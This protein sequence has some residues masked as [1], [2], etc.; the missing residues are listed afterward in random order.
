MLIV[1]KFGGTSVSNSEC[2]FNVAK[3]IKETQ[4]KN[5]NI[6]V[7]VSAQGDTTDKFLEKV[8]E[9][10]QLASKREIDVL[11]SAGEQIS[12]ALLAMALEK[13][14][15]K[16]ISLTGWQAGFKTCKSYGN[17]RIEGIFP[18]RIQYELAQNKVVIVAGFQGINQNYDITTMGRGGSDTSA[19]ALA[20]AL[21]ADQCR[22]YTDVEGIYTANPRIVPH[23]KFLDV[24]PYEDVIQFA[25][26][27]AR[28]LNKRS[29]EIA[30]K[31]GIEISVLS[32]FKN[33][34]NSSHSKTLV[35]EIENNSSV[36]NIKG[37]ALDNNL[38]MIKIFN[39]NEINKLSNEFAK[40]KIRVINLCA[41]EKE[42]NLLINK[43]NLPETNLIFKKIIKNLNFKLEDNISK[44][45]VIGSGK[46]TH[47]ETFDK[48]LKILK[49][50]DI[51]LFL[52]NQNIS[53]ILPESQSEEAVR[54]IH[55]NFFGE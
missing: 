41:G 29:V 2:I 30:K 36:R 23:A 18:D 5:N 39:S 14:G 10:N 15:V 7:V 40:K 28:V 22:I 8:S 4:E 24:V 45:S 43:A 3:I 26:L 34:Q 1:E 25:S 47:M 42:L 52:I 38:I 21:N 27:G 35:C 54:K 13:I 33:C 53:V 51:K 50:F 48:I 11:L 6:V 55:K 31:Y 17:A 9:I 12:M 37:I 19:V 49:N 20:A 44:I 32:S 46:E 16:A